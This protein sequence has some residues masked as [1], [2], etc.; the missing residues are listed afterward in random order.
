MANMINSTYLQDETIPIYITLQYAKNVLKFPINP[1]NLTKE[2]D[3]GSETADIEGIGQVSIPTTPKLAKITISSMFWHQNNLVPAALYVMWLEK[4]Q[5]SKKPANLIVTRLNYSMQVTCES[6]KHWINAGEEKDVYFELSLQEY[7]PYGAKRLGVKTN[8]TLLQSLQQ[9]KSLL[10][11]PV[12]VEIPRPTRHKTNKNQTENPYTALKNET[13][14]SI[15]KKI[16]GKT[17]DWKSL[18]DENAKTLGDIY[19]EKEEIPEG[20]KLTL[21]DS[22]IENSSYGIKTVT[23]DTG[24]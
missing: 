20:T 11:P 16:T 5:N 4:W 19:A 21:P 8:A 23:S 9:A 3:S 15:T 10:T 7:R 22:W 18:Y 6:F 1:D 13:L 17:D 24:N 14:I 2:V 12:L